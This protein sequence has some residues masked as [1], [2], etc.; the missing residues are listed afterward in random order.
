MK[1][2]AIITLTLCILLINAGLTEAA[3][4]SK[5]PQACWK[6]CYSTADQCPEG[7]FAKKR[8][9]GL[10]WTCEENMKLDRFGNIEPVEKKEN[11]QPLTHHEQHKVNLKRVPARENDN[12]LGW[13]EPDANENMEVYSVWNK[14]LNKN[15]DCHS[16]SNIQQVNK[17]SL[18]DEWHPKDPSAPEYDQFYDAYDDGSVDDNTKTLEQYLE[19]KKSLSPP[20]PLLKPRKPNEGSDH[21]QWKNTIVSQ[22]KEEGYFI[23]KIKSH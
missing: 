18:N 21:S 8:M 11:D 9:A 10:C 12:A 5:K 2:A 17:F 4:K 7:F 20:I 14:D 13:D 23:G 22:K 1:F 3:K 16:R 15:Y 19:E 6:A